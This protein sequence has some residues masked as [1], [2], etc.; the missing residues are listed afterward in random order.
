MVLFNPRLGDM[1]VH[2][3]PKCINRKGAVQYVHHYAAGTSLKD[4]TN[5]GTTTPA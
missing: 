2:T 5:T 1:E 3:F 4:E